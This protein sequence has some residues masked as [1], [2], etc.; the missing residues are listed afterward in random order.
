MSD[1]APEPPAVAMRPETDR[2][3]YLRI[4]RAYGMWGAF[5]GHASECRGKALEECAAQLGL[6]REMVPA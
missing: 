3:L 5:L 6:V 1:D 4:N 2:E